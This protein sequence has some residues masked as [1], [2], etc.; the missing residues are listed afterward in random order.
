MYFRIRTTMQ[1]GLLAAAAIA[2]QAN[3]F[4][5]ALAQSV[6]PAPDVA[7]AARTSVQQQQLLEQQRD[8]Q[9]RAQTVNAPVVRSTA[10]K[11]EGW[12]QLPIEKPCF[13][14]QTFV[15]DVPSALPDPVKAQGASTLPLDRFAFAREWLEHYAAP[16]QGNPSSGNSSA[17]I[18]RQGL[19][20]IAK[21]LQQLI[22]SRG[23]VTT[24]VLLTEQDLSTG[25]LKLALVPGLVRQL[26]FADPSTRGTWKTAFPTGSDDL[27]NLRDLEQGLEQMKRVTSQDVDMQVVPTDIPGESDVVIAVKRQK[28]WTVV[29]S[30]DN[31]GTRATGKLLG[32]LNVGIDNPLGLNDIFNIGATQDL[33]F[34]D[35]SLGSHGWNGSYSI[36]WG[37]WTGTVSAYTLDDSFTR[38]GQFSSNLAHD[39]RTP[40]TNLLAQ[41][42]VALSRPRTADEYREVIESGVD[43][44]Q[45]LSRMI[46]DMLFLARSDS[47]QGQLPIQTFDA[48]EEAARVAGYYEPMAE[49]AQVDIEVSGAGAVDANALL[50]QRALSN[51]LSNALAHAPAG[52]TITVHCTLT[53]NGTVLAVSDTGPG[54]DPLHSERI[55]ERFYRVDPARNHSASGTG[56]GLA[57]VKSIM[58]IHGGECGV[59]SEPNV[60]T[61]FWLRFPKQ[62][63]S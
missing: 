14:V 47:A 28:P 57:I 45:R 9:E 44:Y 3:S 25:T 17:C 7:N 61:T 59:G 37:Y 26:R 41:A 31:S 49:D 18:G 32:N 22:I 53:A 52:S 5:Q 20:V 10:P 35:K 46:D 16:S 11:A 21:S 8:A 29:A 13:R 12:P 48:I 36:P 62:R 30:I 33:E 27:L 19:D 63:G 4:P 1:R 43:E 56:L 60:R 55:F 39:M 2:A 42:Q 23:Y 51:L 6:P 15:L 38:L 54:I 58:L 50:Y 40:L 34:E 24:R